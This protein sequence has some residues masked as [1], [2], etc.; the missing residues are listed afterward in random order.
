LERLFVKLSMFLQKSVATLIVFG[1]ISQ[2]NH[3]EKQ[4]YRLKK[5]NRIRRRRTKEKQ[6]AVK[7]KR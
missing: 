3:K 7:I 6:V 4:K 1:H 2:L 5:T